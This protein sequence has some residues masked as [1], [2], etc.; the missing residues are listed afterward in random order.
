MVHCQILA[1]LSTSGDIFHIQTKQEIEEKEEPR[2]NSISLFFYS[3][4][5]G[6]A[7]M[8]MLLITKTMN[9]LRK[10]TKNKTNQLQTHTK[11][12]VKNK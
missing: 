7:I 2:T 1:K 8:K 6:Y 9:Q 12:K 4:R 5:Y 3:N 11:S 10:K